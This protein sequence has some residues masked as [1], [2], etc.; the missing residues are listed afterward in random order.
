MSY[1]CEL[2]NLS[3]FYTHSY[4]KTAFLSL[5]MNKVHLSHQHMNISLK[6]IF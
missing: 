6:L 3:Y 4:I 2:K 1:E 5:L